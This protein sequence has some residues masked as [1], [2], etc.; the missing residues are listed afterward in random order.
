MSGDVSS[1]KVRI[2]VQR[3]LRRVSF[4][5]GMSLRREERVCDIFIYE[6]GV[7]VKAHVLTTWLSW[8]L[9]ILTNRPAEREMDSPWVAAMVNE[10]GFDKG[11]VS[12]SHT[13]R[14]K[15]A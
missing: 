7:F 12:N 11:M 6:I 13:S 2:G 3:L 4:T 9:W 10:P 8:V 14:S 15:E 5:W 1:T